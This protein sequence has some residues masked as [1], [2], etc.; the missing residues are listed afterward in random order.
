MSKR[1][2]FGKKFAKVFATVISKESGDNQGDAVDG[3][4][5]EP[6]DEAKELLGAR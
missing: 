4:S 3:Q 6:T 1:G 5:G 2:K